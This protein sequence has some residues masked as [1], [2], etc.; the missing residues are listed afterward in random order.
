VSR[1]FALGL[2]YGTNSVRALVVDVATGEERGTAVAEYRRGEAGVILD[3]R[4]HNLAR[5]HPQDYVVGFFDC[6]R[7]A[8]HGV[9]AESIVGIGVDTTGST[10]M[11]VDERGVPLVYQP[12]FENDP[13]AMA[14][15]WK[16]HTAFEE[17]AEITSLAAERGEPYLDKCGGTYSSEWFWSKVLRCAR[18][19][20]DVFEAAHSWVEAQDCIPAWLCGVEGARNIP[21][22]VCAAGHKAMYSEEWGGLPSA[23]FLSALDPRLGSLRERLYDRAVPAGTKAG[24]LDTEIAAKCGLRAGTPVS[25][26]AFDAHLG[27]VGSGVKP[28]TMVKIIGTSTCDVLVDGPE[29]PDTPGVCGVVPDR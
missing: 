7:G 3:P 18:V 27:A 13:D 21:R 26:G 15:L 22:G 14:W 4:D 10:P 11:P 28:G 8:L 1:P 29:T 20:P 24:G 25:V 23:E 17:A 5:Q 16:D 19:A 9:D 12:R 2:D 6:I